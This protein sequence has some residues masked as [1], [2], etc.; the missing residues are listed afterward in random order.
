VAR[1][2][3]TSLKACWIAFSYCAMPMSLPIFEASSEAFS[4]PAWKIGAVMLGANDQ[5][6]VPAENSVDNAVELWP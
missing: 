3:A 4:A 2:S 1:A 6:R 5:P